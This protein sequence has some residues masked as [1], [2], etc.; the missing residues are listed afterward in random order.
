MSSLMQFNGKIDKKG[1]HLEFYL[2]EKKETTYGWKTVKEME[3][4]I[5]SVCGKEHPRL[6]TVAR[7][8][9]G[10]CGCWVVFRIDGDDV[11]PDLSVP[12]RLE[13]M[14]YGAKRLTDQESSE[15][16]HRG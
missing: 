16:W 14:P 15:L 2:V 7:K 3:P 8:P 9:K 13:K 12:M 4:V 1:V 6:Y 11:V 10:M 5:C